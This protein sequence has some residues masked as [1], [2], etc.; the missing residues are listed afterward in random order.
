M[1][2]LVVLALRRTLPG[3]ALL[4]LV[5]LLLLAARANHG[6]GLDAGPVLD[7]RQAAGLRALARQDVWSVLLVL[8]P[9]V[10]FH[11]ARLGG[12]ACRTWLAPAPAAPL[13]LGAALV[14]GATLACALVTL[15]TAGVAEA[16]VEAHPG[17]RR[18]HTA[19]SPR[20]R[21]DS[22]ARVA[23]S[24]EAPEPGARLCLWLTVAP[25]AGPA[26]S[27]RFTARAGGDRR[28]VEARVAGRTALELEPP[29]GT[30]LELELEHVGAGAPLVIGTR[31]LE[32]LAPLASERLAALA[33]GARA[34]LLLASGCALALGLGSLLRPALAAGL[35]LALVLGAWTRARAPAAFPGADLPQAF[36]ELASGLV[37]APVAPAALVGALIVSACGLALFALSF[38]RAGGGS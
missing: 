34:G 25:G 38:R 5:A 21:L 18:V 28:T 6:A 26:A 29:P 31:G 12:V 32:V 35:V 9:L 2:A 3:W 10:F 30:R 22:L 33:L 24:I 19:E 4:A 36:A 13:W 16:R 20:A 14:L 1:R 8:A 7:E 17:W 27:A 23:W 15:L 11:A 37:P